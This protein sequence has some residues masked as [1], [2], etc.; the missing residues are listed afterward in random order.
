MNREKGMKRG[1]ERQ[2]LS[3]NEAQSELVG[4]ARVSEGFRIMA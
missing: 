3:R 4:S 1:R 2:A